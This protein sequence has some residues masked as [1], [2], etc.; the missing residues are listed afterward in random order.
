MHT[1]ALLRERETEIETEREKTLL[2]KGTKNIDI[3]LGRRCNHFYK[4]KIM[5]FIVISRATCKPLPDTPS[6]EKC[7]THMP[8]EEK[9]QYIVGVDASLIPRLLVARLL[10][11]KLQKY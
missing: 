1:H 11:L 8:G 9:T 10:L 2:E 3:D 5:Q 7:E 6:C 4:I